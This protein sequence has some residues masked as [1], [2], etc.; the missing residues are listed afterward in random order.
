MAGGYKRGECSAEGVHS[1]SGQRMRAAT[2]IGGR[3]AEEKPAPGGQ[4]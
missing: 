2:A 1:P 3:P 4:A